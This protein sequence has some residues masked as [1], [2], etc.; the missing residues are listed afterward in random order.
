MNYDYSTERNKIFTDKGQREFLKVRDR[1]HKLLEEA[2]AFMMFS[3]LRDISGDTWTMM[4]YVD[5]LV[6]LG[7]IKEITP[8]NVPGQ[9][10]VFVA[11]E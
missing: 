2:G 6:E 7:E 8:P 1:A 3:A 5:R 9:N 10:R 4:A 11:K